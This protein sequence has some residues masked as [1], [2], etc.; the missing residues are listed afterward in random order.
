MNS[1]VKQPAINTTQRLSNFAKRELKFQHALD[2]Q[3][4]A[5]ARLKLKKR[6]AYE[7]MNEEERALR[8]DTR[9]K[10]LAD[11]LSRMQHA[12]SH[13]LNVCIDFSMDYEN[14]DRERRSLC[15]QLCVAYGT[16]KKAERPIHLH[17]TSLRTSSNLFEDESAALMTS[18]VQSFQQESLN[19]KPLHFVEDDGEVSDEVSSSSSSSSLSA[20]ELALSKQGVGGW[21]ADLHKR[22]PWEVFPK[23]KIVILSPDARVALSSF[24]SDCVYVIG[25]IVDRSVRKA[26]TAQLAEKF[27]LRCERLPVQEHLPARQTHVFNIDTVLSIICEFQRCGDWRSTLERV[28]PQRKQCRPGNSPSIMTTKDGVINDDDDVYDDDA[29]DHDEDEGQNDNGQDNGD[30]RDGAVE[31]DVSTAATGGNGDAQLSLTS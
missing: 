2:R 7:K 10:A 26:R 19:C 17:L 5:K 29:D 9:K 11:T 21:I 25:G 20:L 18:P 12:Q 16:L 28:V 31:V 1:V 24:D 15:K 13:G 8:S 30:D 27:G 6:E 23:D 22:H 3:K 14:N 4:L